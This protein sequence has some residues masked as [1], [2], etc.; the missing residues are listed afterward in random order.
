MSAE[1]HTCRVMYPQLDSTEIDSMHAADP[2][3]CR[4]WAKSIPIYHEPSG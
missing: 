1:V 4:V 3:N 2:A